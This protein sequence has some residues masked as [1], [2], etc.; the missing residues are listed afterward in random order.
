MGKEARIN[1]RIRTERHAAAKTLFDR[2]VDQIAA[3][4]PGFNG[5]IYSSTDPLFDLYDGRE[6]NVF[7]RELCRARL[8]AKVFRATYGVDGAGDVENRHLCVVGTYE[9]SL[10][11]TW[12]S[13]E[14]R[15][16]IPSVAPAGKYLLYAAL[17]DLR[18]M[19]FPQKQAA[20]E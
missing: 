8:M 9:A 11:F 19:V 1:A 14:G 15:R 10:A 4:N 5:E 18:P 3:R 7:V 20:L 6:L 17:G 16:D 12:K 13:N 2:V